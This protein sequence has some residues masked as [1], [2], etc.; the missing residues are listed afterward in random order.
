MMQ[1]IK[2]TLGC[3]KDELNGKIIT[4]FI[5]LKPKSYAFK[6]YNQEKEEKKNKGV[7]KQKVKRELNYKKYLETLEDNTCDTVRFNSI[8][9]KN[10]QVY[11][12]NQVK[13]ALSSY[14][15][16]RYWYDKI[17]SYP[18]GHFRISDLKS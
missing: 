14:C 13:Q 18:Y 5:G 3:Y 12:I 8:R 9:S 1:R 10:H 4:N 15:N 7:P 6:V 2:K 16:K 17:N 11:S